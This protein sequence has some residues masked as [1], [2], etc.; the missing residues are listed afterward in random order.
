[1]MSRRS[2]FVAAAGAAL[3]AV[4]AFAAERIDYSPSAFD[5][6]LKGGKSILV[7]IHAP[8]CPTCKA[9]KP[10]LAKIEAE[11]RLQRSH[12]RPRGFR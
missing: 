6:A 7:E 2:L 12:R 1:M 3:F 11:A 10:I 8:W 5:A 4:P 9:Q